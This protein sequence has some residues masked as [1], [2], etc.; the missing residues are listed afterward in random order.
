M[1]EHSS[2]VKGNNDPTVV[3][4]M[5]LRTAM[6]RDV[7]EERT[8]VNFQSF[9]KQVIDIMNGTDEE[10]PWNATDMQCMGMGSLKRFFQQVKFTKIKRERNKEAYRLARVF[11]LGT[12]KKNLDPNVTR[13]KTH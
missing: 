10:I 1:G 4:S 12:T 5:A 8:K 13:Q 6:K 2:K 9:N 3:E 11:A 7:R